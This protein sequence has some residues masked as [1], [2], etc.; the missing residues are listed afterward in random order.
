LTT[1]Q[2]GYNQP[3]SKGL[4]AFLKALHG[5]ESLQNLHLNNIKFDNEAL[6]A[7]NKMLMKNQCLEQINLSNCGI[8]DDAIPKLKQ[9]LMYNN[10]LQ[11][12]YFCWQKLI[13]ITIVLAFIWKQNYR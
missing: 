12:F 10:T 4:V 2:L 3:T 6:I 7:L 11:V 13:L 8:N 9:G 1:L 5:E